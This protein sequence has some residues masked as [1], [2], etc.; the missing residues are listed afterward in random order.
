MLDGRTKE[1]LVNQKSVA[2]LSQDLIFLDSSLA[3]CVTPSCDCL[4]REEMLQLFQLRLSEKCCSY[5]Y[6][7]AY[8][9]C[10]TKWAKSRFASCWAWQEFIYFRAEFCPLNIPSFTD[11]DFIPGVILTRICHERKLLHWS[12]AYVTQE[13]PSFTHCP[14]SMHKP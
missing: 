10:K 9:T 1:E 12:A 8:E 5:W 4:D 6:S 2:E 7:P 14:T 3:V 13:T 11:K